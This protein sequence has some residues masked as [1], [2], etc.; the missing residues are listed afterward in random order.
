MM[1]TKSAKLMTVNRGGFL[2]R[3]RRPFWTGL[4]SALLIGWAASAQT[5]PRQFLPDQVRAAV[6]RLAPEGR[7][8]ATTNL[9]LNIGLPLRDP[10]ALDEL[11]R[12]LYDPRSPDF[13]K[14]ISPAEF[15]ARFGPSEAEYQAVMNFARA[16]G[17]T[18][19]GTHPNRLVLDVEGSA[20]N[21]E[22]AFQ[23]TLRTY[24]HP[25]EARNFFAP[26]TAP[27]VPANLS[28]VTVEGLDDFKHPKPLSHPVNPLKARPLGGTGPGGYYAG[29]D[30]R[31]AYVP[32]T[33]LNGTGQSV[34]LLEFSA[35]YKSDIT[36]YE[37]TVGMTTFVPLNNVVIGH[38]G[39]GTA[40][41]AEVALDIEVAIALAP[42]LSQVIVYEIR[43]G[44][45][46]ILN[47]MATDNLARQLSSSW[48]WS[49]GP[50]PTIDNILKQMAA[51]GQSFFQASGDSDAYTGSQTLDNASQTTAPVDSTNLTSVGG[52]TLTMNGSGAS[53]SSETVWNWNNSGQPNVGSGGGISTYYSIPWWQAGANMAANSGSTVWRNIPDVALTADNVFVNYNNGSS[54]GFGG[55]SC[56][57]PLWAG[58][59]ALVN[60]Q[61]AAA[62]GTA[63]GFLNPALY[64]IANSA[65]Y[66]NCFHDITTGNNIGSGT[67]GLFYA[68]AGYDLATG[69]GTPNGTNLINALAPMP[70]LPYI[71][72]QPVSRTA[73]NGNNVTFGV[74][75]GGPAPFTFQWL[76]NG[77]NLPAGGNVSGT[78]SNTL[79]LTS[80][81]TAN[82]GNYSVLV[83]NNYGSVTSSVA[84]LT[85]VFPPTFTAQPANQTVFAGSN[86]VFGA[87]VTG[88]APLAYRWR[89]NGANLANNGNISGATSNVL[90]FTSVTP[91]NAGN[92][93]LVATNLYGSATS[94]VAVL[95][96]VQ[97]AAITL[98]PV[99][100]T[101]QCG[102]NASFSVTASGTAPLN[103][104]WS[105][106]DAPL[107]A[108]TNTSLSLTNI[109]PPGHTVMVVVT[110]RYGGATSSV[111]L[112][113][114]DT[115]PPVIALISPDPLYV[116]LGGTYTDP[117]A[118]AYDSCAG[119]VPATASGAVNP[120]AAGTNIVT[121][122]ADDGNGN[123]NT[124]TRTVIV[125]DTTPP[126]ISWSF[127]NLVLA[128]GTNCTATMPDVTGTNSV[129]ATDLSGPLT[130]TQDP[131]SGTGLPP[132]TNSMSLAVSDAFGNTAYSA[133]TIVVQDQAPPVLV[134]Q[135]QNQTNLA[136]STA[137]FGVLA[138][139]CTPLAVQWYFENA[140][141]TAQTNDTLTL[142]N[143]AL[144]AAGE[145][146][147]VVSADGGSTTSRV[148][149]LTVE[150]I[151]PV[152]A[153]A[154]SG[155]P[156]G[157]NDN[158]TFTA[159]LTPTNVTGTVQFLTNGV[160]FD[161]EPLAA[162]TAVSTNLSVLP[163]GT[164][165]IT[166]IYSGDASD[167]PVTNTLAQ[168]VTNHP[169]LVAEVS[170]DRLA[171]YPVAIAAA[172]LAASWSDADGDT[173]S[174]AAI[175][176]STDGVTVTNNA[177]TL[178][179]FDTNDVDDHFICAISD[180][181]GGTNFQTV[182]IN[183]VLTNTIPHIIGVGGDSNGSVTLSLAGAPGYTYVL[184]AT[185]D[186]LPPTDWLPMATNIMGTNGVW[187]F[188]DQG[189]T[190]FPQRF[191][192]L[193]LSQ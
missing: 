133:N 77:T 146:F 159:S 167:L 35:Y 96:V 60:Q 70:S 83:A 12:Q 128:A 82:A 18:V 171:G 17:L 139:A 63:V 79:T 57:A 137:N 72:A 15:A 111:A 191:Y 184:E 140:A 68:V 24:R 108:A 87:T 170:Y 138:T 120:S 1:G 163:R 19:A 21:V 54:G 73:T 84:A 109:H 113:V 165:A 61:S 33:S 14:F 168:V 103:F 56:A 4:G 76:L 55:T 142:T 135:P 95:T 28:V 130:I 65:D 7:L 189:T 27:S 13:H 46:S 25:G 176:V 74:T 102:S 44:P 80:V 6:S 2:K 104:Q 92:Y 11:L 122:A 175:G 66:G 173:V 43:S 106:D 100:Q 37:K 172:D 85:V 50:S 157:F 143:V 147:A 93:T 152:L 182:Y 98:P 160:A 141:L 177:G 101:I 62:N 169:P 124:V 183:I 186:L 129:L 97:P 118:V 32:G 164:N 162:G 136:H 49:G 5:A 86:A 20:S 156:A 29:N 53:W 121:Y 145:Y 155:N 22:R 91:T 45:S 150:L 110:N 23:T 180:D 51:Q 10:A 161:T 16:N 181:W 116:E 67:P 59:C 34:G 90:A 148:V 40:N 190:N 178:V 114:Q 39:P 112:A 88:A 127:T 38:P 42:K 153:L 134:S 179:Y 3:E 105:L 9:V 48:S 154:S 36:N 174:L 75:V 119:F 81:T 117:G 64:A 125:R 126:A 151:S 71:T 30:F 166:A 99:G 158:L 185:T 8:P 123:T 52:T 131:V 78:A 187:P 188:T 149:T 132:G 41:N 144:P 115:L 192:R 193:K 107:P 89:Q 58:F 26:D 69:L 94:G 47:R 31:N